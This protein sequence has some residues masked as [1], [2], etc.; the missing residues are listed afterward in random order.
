MVNY[1]IIV[2]YD[3]DRTTHESIIIIT[4]N[5]HKNNFK[6]SKKAL[7][8]G[9]TIEDYTDTVSGIYETVQEIQF[10]L[11]SYLNSVVTLYS[12]TT[13][14]SWYS[15]PQ[16]SIVEEFEFSKKQDQT[17][18]NNFY[19]IRNKIMYF[20]GVHDVISNLRHEKLIS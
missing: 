2:T 8:N 11:F 15:D 16:Y 17:L 14:K 19:D 18:T 6:V 12:T 13:I 20:R 9:E 5:K 7:I 1:N 10:T 4:H 3:V